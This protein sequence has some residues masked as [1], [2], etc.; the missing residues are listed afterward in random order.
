MRVYTVYMH[1]FK[2]LML[3]KVIFLLVPH[4]HFHHSVGFMAVDNLWHHNVVNSITV[5][6]LQSFCGLMKLFTSPVSVDK[7]AE[8]V[9][10]NAT[11]D[12]KHTLEVT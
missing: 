12:T 7:S 4:D 3:V 1:L 9:L 10:L 11:A 2:K 8:Q 5:T 6:T